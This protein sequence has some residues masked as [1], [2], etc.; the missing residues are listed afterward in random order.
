MLTIML[1][2]YQQCPL[3]LNCTA[4][5]CRL[6][7]ELVVFHLIYL[8]SA[9]F[10][11]LMFVCSFVFVCIAVCFLQHSAYQNGPVFYYSIFCYFYLILFIYFSLS[12]VHV[13]FDVF[14]GSMEIIFQLSWI[15]IILPQFAWSI[16]VWQSLIPSHEALLSTHESS[17][18]S[19]VVPP[20]QNDVWV[21][22][23]DI[24]RNIGEKNS[25]FYMQ[26]Y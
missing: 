17:K 6:Q 9:Q 2:S 11:C 5:Y 4:T 19:M 8:V 18:Q 25:Q 3:P 14:H 21:S 26:Q 13:L 10:T 7:C 15:I 20:G 22:T 23:L 16:P 24:S 1:S 12:V